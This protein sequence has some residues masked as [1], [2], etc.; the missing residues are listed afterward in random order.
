MPRRLLEVG[1][2]SLSR[3]AKVSTD[4]LANVLAEERVNRWEGYQ[5]GDCSV[6]TVPLVP[7]KYHVVPF[8]EGLCVRLHPFRREV[9]EICVEA[10]AHRGTDLNHAL[11]DIL[12]GGT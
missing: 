9:F 6:E 4:G 1:L 7:R 10:H 2:R 12:Q 3:E 5:V 8:Q 11:E